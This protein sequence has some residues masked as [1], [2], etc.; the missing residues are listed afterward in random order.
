MKNLFFDRIKTVVLIIKHFTT[1]FITLRTRFDG[2]AVIISN[3]IALQL[4]MKGESI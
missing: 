2:K 4:K 3:N 1:N